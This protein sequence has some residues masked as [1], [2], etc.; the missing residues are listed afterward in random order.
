MLCILG[1]CLK[2]AQKGWSEQVK[3]DTLK[4]DPKE[5]RKALSPGV[6]VLDDLDRD[7]VISVDDDETE[8]LNTDITFC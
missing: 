6:D 4:E 8:Y 2:L 3:A 7:D 5:W 1:D